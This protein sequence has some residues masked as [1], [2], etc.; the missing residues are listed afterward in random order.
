MDIIDIMLARALTPQGQ[1]DI[2]VGK[3]NK[4][5]A[6]AEQAKSDAED[7]VATVEA[8][9]E[10]IAAAQESAAELLATAQE[11]LETAQQ[12]QLNIPDTE[13]IDAEVKKMVVNTNVVDGQ[14]AK[15]LQVISTYPDNTLNTQ[16]ITKLYKAT[17][18]NEDG[19]MTQKA[20]TDALDQKANTTVLNNYA[21]IQY[22]NQAVANI[23]GSGSGITINTD[24]GA[25]NV[26]K[27]VVIDMNGNIIS[28]TV[29][30]EDIIQALIQSGGY[31]ARDA[32]GLEIDYENKS[33]KRTQEAVNKSMGSDFNSYP[34]YGGR[35]RCVVLNDGTIASFEGDNDHDYVTSDVGAVMVYQPKFY[36]QRIPL[37]TV[38]GRTGKIVQRDSIMVS[39]TPQNGFKV[40]PLFIDANGEELDYVLLSAYEGGLY[41]TNN[42]APDTVANGTEGYLLTSNRNTK[43][44]TGT[45]GLTLEKAEQLATNRGS[46]WHIMNI[47]AESANQMLELIEFGT[48][49]GQ[50]ALGKGVC[51]M[52]AT[53]TTSVPAK[54]GSTML[55][56]STS[57]SASETEFVGTNDS[58]FSET[59]AGKVSINYR[60][61]E[62]PWGN[63][64]NMLGGILVKGTTSTG[65]GI[66]YICSDF[67]YSYVS[68][69]NN[70]QSVEFCLPNG[71]GWISNLGY[72]NSN[73]DWLL[74][75]ADNDSS[76]N[77]ALPIGDNGWFDSN[78]A[79]IRA[80]AYGG[81]YSFG[82]SDGPFYYACD[83]APND[84][85]YKSYGARLMFIPTKNDIYTANIAKW[86]Q[87]MNMG[88]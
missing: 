6:K 12:A 8:A 72:G 63:S 31:T 85:T 53:G 44:L 45:R 86:Q 30:E 13:D 37:S 76:A 77:S 49:N 50:N 3:A 64:W 83:K 20:I 15:T 1:T 52:P 38:N 17:G 74:M 48:L 25:E 16:N 4:A 73:F 41:H 46:G 28:G 62:N 22:V 54:T 35:K 9:A 29:T 36:Y 88:G 68:P 66:P 40:H 78:L 67:N 79:G 69:S 39:A 42:Q 33:F 32:V 24:L 19:T 80:V 23:P 60:G 81:S 21:S 82:E 43:V 65:G 47:Q 87:T 61:V 70:Y 84:T 5:A 14:N 26:G 7:A 18:S 51:D 27:I 11:T 34:M 58:H 2:Y 75:P 71:N 55:L 57:G 10:E 59:V 56:E